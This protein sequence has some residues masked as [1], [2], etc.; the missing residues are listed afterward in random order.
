MVNIVKTLQVPGEHIGHAGDDKDC[1]NTVDRWLV[2]GITEGL[3][4]AFEQQ[5]WPDT[6]GR[7]LREAWTQLTGKEPGRGYIERGHGWRAWYEDGTPVEYGAPLLII[8]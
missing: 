4:A 7:D 6:A 3:Q 2:G 5:G 1:L 8:E